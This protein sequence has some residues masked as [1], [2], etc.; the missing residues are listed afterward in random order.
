MTTNLTWKRT[1]ADRDTGEDLIY[2]GTDEN[3]AVVGYVR[4]GTAPK[5]YSGHFEY[6]MAG[7]KWRLG[8]MTMTATKRY[9]EAL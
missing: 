6:K 5:G 8:G 4:K 3:G 2:T 1:N 7:G 9:V